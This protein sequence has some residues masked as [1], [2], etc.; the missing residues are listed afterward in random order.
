MID[1]NRFRS[2][3]TEDPRRAYVSVTIAD[4]EFHAI[5]EVVELTSDFD[6]NLDEYLYERHITTI[7]VL[8]DT[9]WTNDIAHKNLADWVQPDDIDIII[10]K[11]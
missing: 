4:G 7:E 3:D 11:D 2:N 6:E 9:P 10:I 1:I 5:C 8:G